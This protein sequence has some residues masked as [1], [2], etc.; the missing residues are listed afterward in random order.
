MMFTTYFFRMA[1]AI[2]VHT[3]KLTHSQAYHDDYQERFKDSF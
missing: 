2:V 3:E 1:I